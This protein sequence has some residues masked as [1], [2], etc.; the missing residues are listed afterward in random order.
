MSLKNAK[1]YNDGD[2]RTSLGTMSGGFKDIDNSLDDLPDIGS[3][4]LTILFEF[5]N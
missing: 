4:M 1:W 5:I 3:A 2:N